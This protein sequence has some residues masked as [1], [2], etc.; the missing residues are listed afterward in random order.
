MSVLDILEVEKNNHDE[1]VK[2]IFDV[3]WRNHENLHDYHE[4]LNDI[5]TSVSVGLL[6]GNGWMVYIT[7]ILAGQSDRFKHVTCKLLRNLSLTELYLVRNKIIS[8]DEKHNEVFRDMVEKRIVD[9]SVEV[10]FY[11]PVIKYFKDGML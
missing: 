9:M 1:D 5:I 6:P 8:I 11:P 7:F 3:F 4:V 10:H 2:D